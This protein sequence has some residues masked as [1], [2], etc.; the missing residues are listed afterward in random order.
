MSDMDQAGM[1]RRE[2][3]LGMGGLAV[4]ITSFGANEAEAN[5]GQLPHYTVKNDTGTE[6]YMKLVGHS[7]NWVC[8][9]DDAFMAP[10]AEI[11][12]DLYPGE[13]FLLVWDKHKRPRAVAKIS[14][15]NSPGHISIFIGN[16]TDA[17]KIK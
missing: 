11:E 6:I 12:D 17:S 9:T 16:M 5:F 13:R 8:Q 14:I 1:T 10:N 4:V 2:M 15:G 3:V 7:N